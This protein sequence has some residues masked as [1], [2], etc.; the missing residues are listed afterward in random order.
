[1]PTP[2]TPDEERRFVQ[3]M[4][5]HVAA[6]L[7]AGESFRISVYPHLTHLF[8]EVTS[9]AATR[10]GRPVTGYSNGR[11]YFISLPPREELQATPR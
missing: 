6:Q 3:T 2:L 10:L 8:S 7:A 9:E 4:A 5:A 1:M 11:E